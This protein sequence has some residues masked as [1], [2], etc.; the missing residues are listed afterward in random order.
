MYYYFLFIMIDILN[1]I[2]IFSVFWHKNKFLV[3]FKNTYIYYK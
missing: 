3:L 2:S 1:H